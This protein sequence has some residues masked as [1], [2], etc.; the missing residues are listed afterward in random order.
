[1]CASNKLRKLKVIWFIS[2]DKKEIMTLWPPK[3]NTHN[4]RIVE[5]DFMAT[6][7]QTVS[8]GK[9]ILYNSKA[10]ERSWLSWLWEWVGTAANI[11][12]VLK[13]VMRQ[14]KEQQKS[15]TVFTSFE[16]VQYDPQLWRIRWLDRCPDGSLGKRETGGCTALSKLKIH[17]WTKR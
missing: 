8:K 13:K 9:V 15:E 5:I 11:R 12:S 6:F 3:Y 1:M 7:C 10:Q 16:L 2:I 17:Y 4:K 14:R